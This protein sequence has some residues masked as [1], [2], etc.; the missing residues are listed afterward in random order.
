MTETFIYSFVNILE[1][2]KEFCYI[3]FDWSIIGV[4]FL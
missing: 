3:I 1:K 4:V 2:Q